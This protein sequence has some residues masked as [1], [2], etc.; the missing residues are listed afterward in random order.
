MGCSFEDDDRV[1]SFESAKKLSPLRV[2]SFTRLNAARDAIG[3]ARLQTIF[4]SSS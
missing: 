1:D 2:W 3:R 4:L